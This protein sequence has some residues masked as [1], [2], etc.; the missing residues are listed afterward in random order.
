MPFL[1]AIRRAVGSRTFRAE[2][3]GHLIELRIGAGGGE[4]V[5]VNGAVVSHHPWAYLTGAHDHPFPLTGPDGARHNAEV[6]VQDRSG[7]L[8][9]ALRVGVNIDGKPFATLPEIDDDAIT[10]CPHC[11]YDLK[12]LEPVNQEVKCPECGRHTALR[13]LR[14]R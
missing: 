4:T 12:G 2:V 11:G 14:T 8:Q 1:R 3:L 7:G 6:R 9:A 10:N 13:L 5:L